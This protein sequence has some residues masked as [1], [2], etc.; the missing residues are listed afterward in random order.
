MSFVH[1]HTHTEYSLLDGAC[2]IAPLVSQVRDMGQT[3]VAI[4]DHGNM[5]GV[6]DFYKECKKQGVKP[7]IGCEVYVA[8]RSRFDRVHGTDSSPYHLVLLCQNEIG[9]NNLMKLVSAGYTEGFYSKPR[10]DREL[11]TRHSD[12]LICLSACLGG[13]IPRRLLEGDYAAAK[14]A[15]EFYL[16]VFG[17]DRFYIEL[18]DHG[19][20]EQKRIL[21][22]L[23]RI[24]RETGAGLVAANDAHYIERSDSKIHNVLLCIQTNQVV[25]QDNNFEFSGSEFYLKSSGEMEELFGSYPEA[26]ENTVKIADM[27]SLEFEFGVT[28]LPI[29]HTP[30]G[31]DNAEYFE[32]LCYDGLNKRYGT[33]PPNE[34]TKRLEY[35]ISVIKQMGFVDYFLIV[36]DFIAYAKS[37]GISVGPGRGSGAGS[38]AAY[39]IGITGVDPIEHNLLFER[40]LNP[41]RVSM[42][43]FDID[44]CY[45]RRGE[46][47]DYV[48][49]KYG[50]DH[51]AQ[52][53]TFGTMAAKGAVRDVGR[54]LGVSY[55]T[56]D[57]LAKQIPWSLGITIKKA[58]EVSAEF[59]GS[60]ENDP[61]AREIID[62]AIK[63]EGMPRHA[64][65]HAAGVVI[66]RD[67]VDEYVPIAK[68]DEAVV[69]QYPMNTLEAL[70]LLKMDF[71]GLRTLTVISDTERSVRRYNPQF[72]IETIPMDDKKVYEML[73]R[74]ETEGVFQFESS[75]VVQV[76]QRL[77]PERFNDLVVTTSLY[78]SGPIEAGSVPIL[79]KNRHDTNNIKYKHPLLKPALEETYG[80]M[81]YQEQV[82]WILRELAGFSYGRADIVRRAIGKKKADVI[83]KERQA[84]IHG[85][86]GEDGN[87]ECEG[88]VKRGVS[89]KI[90]NQIFDEMAG[91]AS[92][93]FNKSHAAAYALIAYRTAYLKANY[94][95]EYFAALF[96]SVLDNTDKIIE[97]VSECK[98]LGIAILPPCV[99]SSGMGFAP[100]GNDIRYGLLAIKNIGRGM[101]QSILAEREQGAFVSLYDFVRRM[102]GKDINKRAVESLIKSGAFDSFPHN[103]RQMILAY[104]EIMESADNDRRTTI[105]GQ[106][107]LFGDSAPAEHRMPPIGELD[108]NALS[109]MEK[110]SMG[111]Y[112][113]SH[114]LDGYTALYKKH[115]FDSI[116]AIKN[117]T[118]NTVYRDRSRVTVMGIVQSKKTVTTKKNEQMAFVTIED[119]SG[120]IEVIM[121]ADAYSEFAAVITQNSVAVISGTVT[122]KEDEPAKIV[123]ER[124]VS[125]QEYIE[126]KSLYL[127]VASKT[128]SRL[129][130]VY[131]EIGRSPGSS[132]VYLY[133]TDDGKYRKLPDKYRTT[134]SDGTLNK[135][136]IILGTG[137][138]AVR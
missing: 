111:L 4:T 71:L 92:Y 3:A 102:S 25:G 113:S 56:V 78:R 97:Y 38:L 68:N 126:L 37:K 100:E 13:E 67:R 137:N 40:F 58:L 27:C 117:D 136:E 74:G 125:P 70:G 132:P 123:C 130:A 106:I 49:R 95:K 134:I 77:K 105:S 39:C 124:A 121:F 11:I 135:M 50:A 104:Q 72:D 128:D 30:D 46:V 65:T 21:P 5:Y 51:V 15:A 31:Q 60:Y 47:I 57:R 28:K 26:L 1:L 81:L 83:P 17:R 133:C 110:E 107:S 90:A 87:I 122:I 99:N 66:T 52:I 8:P 69:T 75:G 62:T 34:A 61:T 10:I 19:L 94:K 127:K 22:L 129:A 54:A 7:I 88:A 43:D 101:I 118:G 82:M 29:F 20:D 63:L 12:G 114:P 120:T 44:F 18:Q 6:I 85:V 55:Q 64:S 9:Y 96:T 14:Q 36:H 116:S 115:S 53:I 131:S 80:V 86:V 119:R 2:R 84:F 93:A 32:S 33:T 91:F 76:L 23:L 109:A 42:P 73:S 24:G 79:I 41:E 138:A 98:K 103:R 112:I 45:E 108:P 35:E 48:T 59:R 89:E 16:G